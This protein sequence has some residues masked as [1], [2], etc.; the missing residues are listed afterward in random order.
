MPKCTT[1]TL[2]WLSREIQIGPW[3][4][5]SGAFG[6]GRTETKPPGTA[7]CTSSGTRTNYLNRL[8][9]FRAVA[10]SPAPRIR[11]GA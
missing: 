7:A 1:I 3:V 9:T 8:R 6:I 4:P 2:I 11:A 10:I 5:E